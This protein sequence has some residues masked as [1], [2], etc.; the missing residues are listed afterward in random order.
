M[1][2]ALETSRKHA[3]TATEHEA[4]S[5]RERGMMAPAIHVRIE[6]INQVIQGLGGEV[7]NIAGNAAAI[8]AV[9]SGTVVLRNHS[10]GFGIDLHLRWRFF[11]RTGNQ[12]E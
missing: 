10:S 12:D 11:F 3:E 2:D 4:E 8:H 1:V 6:R 9:A 7:W 5:T